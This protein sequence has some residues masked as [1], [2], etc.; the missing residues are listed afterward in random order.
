MLNTSPENRMLNLP[1]ELKSFRYIN[2]HI[3]EE[4]LP[5]AAFDENLRQILLECTHFDWS[6]ISPA[7]FGSMFQGI[8]DEGLRRELGAHYTSEE[9]ILK[10][11]NALFMDDLWEEFEKVK[12]IK[13]DLDKFHT[14]LGKI[15]I[16]DPACGSGNFLII[17]YRELRLLEFEVL[18][19]IYDNTNARFITDQG[20][21]LV[22]LSNFY[23]IEIEDFAVKIAKIGMI[24]IKHQLDKQISNYFGYNLIDFPVKEEANIYEGNSLKTNWDDV[25]TLTDDEKENGLSYIVGNPPFVGKNLQTKEQQ[26]ESKIVLRDIKK[27][28]SLDY[29]ANWYKKAADFMENTNVKTALVSTNSICQGEQATIL[30]KNF[31]EKPN[32]NINFA[33]QTFKWTNEAKGKAGVY[34]IIVGFSYT[35]SK[36]KYIFTYKNISKPYEYEK[37]KVEN[38]N[39]YL[40]D[41]PTI[42]VET[43]QTQISGQNKM[44]FGSMPNDGGNFILTHEEKEFLEN[45]YPKLKEENIIRPYVGAK[46]FI[47]RTER[48]VLWMKGKNVIDFKNYPEIL[49]RIEKVK[50]VRLQSSAAS[51]RKA[52]STPHL[53]FSERQPESENYLI[54]P[55]V[56][57]EKRVYIPIGFMD[58]NVISSDLN[59]VL[60]G[61]TL[62]EF[63][64]ISSEMH[65]D[66]TRTVCG[67]LKSDYRYTN[68]IVYNNFV[69]PELDIL[70]EDS[71]DV[72]KKKIELKE[73]I[74]E[75]AKKVLE[76]RERYPDYTFADLYDPL[77]MPVDLLDAHKALDK[78]VENT[79]GK[80]F[81]NSFERVSYLFKLYEEKVEE[82]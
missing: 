68:T 82:A 17:A 3:F 27:N 60:P 44:N 63:G 19:M 7:I 81:K 4:V 36:Q 67:R 33:H 53:F 37:N 61:A 32:F 47:E 11:V 56:S 70:D 59:N 29:V 9:N 66:W 26:E 54:V 64:V 22:K 51:T 23:G 39:Q 25:F 62:Y 38:I 52:A 31:F 18:K 30:W 8:M 43:R 80:S 28:R 58:S 2:G 12:Y 10:T 35:K 46:E 74:E 57:S 16:F 5:P 24:L 75:K 72:R 48:Y 15:K 79:Y 41:A 13:K 34:C 45:K 55:R 73:N 77:F 1:E 42:S 69:F 50:E 78:A 71:E 65:M 40:V 49:E 76:V 21:R 20:F 14:K 6:F